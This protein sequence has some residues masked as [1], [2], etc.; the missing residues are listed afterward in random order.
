MKQYRMGASALVYLTP[1]KVK[2]KANGP[3]NR[4]RFFMK[5]HHI[6]EREFLRQILDKNVVRIDKKIDDNIKEEGRKLY[7]KLVNTFKGNTG[8]NIFMADSQSMDGPFWATKIILD[9]KLYQISDGI[10]TLDDKFII[11]TEGEVYGY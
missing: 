4:L 7:R 10:L 8:I 1:D 11:E 2:E 9:K 6:D 5:I 3:Y